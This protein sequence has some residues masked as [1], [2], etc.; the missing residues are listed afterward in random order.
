MSLYI[1]H[2]PLHKV[3]VPNFCRLYSK[4]DEPENFGDILAGESSDKVKIFKELIER[5]TEYIINKYTDLDSE[6]EKI[7]FKAED[8]K[9]RAMSSKHI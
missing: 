6:L 5:L 1:D 4:I 3:L 8:Q 2:A 7:S 9:D